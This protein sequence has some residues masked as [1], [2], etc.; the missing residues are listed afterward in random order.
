MLCF[1]L[2]T[3]FD[4]IVTDS[5]VV[6]SKR[7]DAV[8]LSDQFTDSAGTVLPYRYYLPEGA[9]SGERYP[10]LLYLHGNGSRGS[11]NRTQLTT[12]GAALNT[13]ILNSEY[14]CIMIAPQC[15]TGTAW[16]ADSRYPGSEAFN[17][18]TEPG[19]YLS[20]AKELL[21]YFLAEYRCDPDRIY[22]TGSSNGGGA[23]WELISRYPGLFAAA[24]PLAGTGSRDGAKAFGKTVTGTPV[25]TFHGDADMT[26]SVEGTRAI[27]SAIREAGGDVRYT[28]IAGGTHDIWSTAAATEG[29]IDWIFAQK[30]GGEDSGISSGESEPVSGGESSAG[31]GSEAPTTLPSQSADGDTQPPSGEDETGSGGG[32]WRTVLLLAAGTVCLGAVI[33]GIAAAIKSKKGR[34]GGDGRKA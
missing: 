31:N 15:P 34:N 33:A 4:T 11:D 14:P 1:G 5:S 25:W 26:L 8:F 23:T 21:D 3:G 10:V 7:P 13:A 29:L 6:T 18:T 28:E 12:N 2:L 19:K 30:R 27:V 24:V 20:A 17:G 22:I 16:V 32:S 9:E